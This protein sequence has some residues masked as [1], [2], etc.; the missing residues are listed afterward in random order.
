MLLKNPFIHSASRFL[1]PLNEPEHNMHKFLLCVLLPTKT[2]RKQVRTT[3]LSNIPRKI[4][5][6]PRHSHLLFSVSVMKLRFNSIF[7]TYPKSTIR[8]HQKSDLLQPFFFYPCITFDFISSYKWVYREF[9]VQ[10]L[11]YSY[12]FKS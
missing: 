10:Y 2:T 8:V 12:R 6:N 5:H 3:Q 11:L 9:F 4:M 1:N 7:R